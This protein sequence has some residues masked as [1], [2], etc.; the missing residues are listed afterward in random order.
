[1]LGIKHLRKSLGTFMSTFQTQFI[2]P[3]KI[4][5]GGSK[6]QCLHV[7][8]SAQVY[9]GIESDILQHLVGP[10]KMGTSAT[11]L[12]ATAKTLPPAWKPSSTPMKINRNYL[13]KRTQ[14]CYLKPLYSMNTY[15]LA[16]HTTS[17]MTLLAG[18]SSNLM[19]DACCRWYFHCGNRL[20]KPETSPTLPALRRLPPNLRQ[21][22]V[23]SI[24]HFLHAI[25]GTSV[26]IKVTVTNSNEI[27]PP[28]CQTIFT[29]M[30]KNKEET[31]DEG[32]ERHAEK[33]LCNDVDKILA[34][35]KAT[36]PNLKKQQKITVKLFQNNSPCTLC[37]SDLLDFQ[38]KV[39]SSTMGCVQFEVQVQSLYRF[40]Y[41]ETKA[42]LKKLDHEGMEVNSLNWLEFYDALLQWVDQSFCEVKSDS[43][44]DQDSAEEKC[45]QNEKDI[46]FHLYEVSLKQLVNFKM[47][48]NYTAQRDIN[49]HVKTKNHRLKSFVIHE[50]QSI[51]SLL[52]E[53]LRWVKESQ[54]EDDP[55][56][57]M[58]LQ[59]E[60]EELT[61]NLKRILIRGIPE[62]T[63]QTNAFLAAEILKILGVTETQITTN[64]IGEKRPRPILVDLPNEEAK[65]IALKNRYKIRTASGLCYNPKNVFISECWTKLQLYAK[66]VSTFTPRDSFKRFKKLTRFLRKSKNC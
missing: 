62:D 4:Y 8:C 60:P 58:L 12:L 42:A 56:I 51:Q 27:S 47:Y 15:K 13:L 39:T 3:L 48:Q 53:T 14:Q 46:I 10:F 40:Q 24:A 5:G 25:K 66:G 6:D 22:Q 64:R 11:K 29:E 38:N 35:I 57:K 18:Q 20:A 55:H 52:E 1:M 2:Q 17:M 19:T 21:D 63:G 43:K 31:V 61:L 49:K 59:T 44:G 41:P 33:Q 23:I 45:P 26:L 30:Y 50:E 34:A 9:K 54:L 37:V 16:L 7:C 32:N 36:V 65:R 28:H